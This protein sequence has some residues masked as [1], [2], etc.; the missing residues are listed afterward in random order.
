MPIFG[1]MPK[2]KGGDNMTKKTLSEIILDKLADGASI[3]QLKREY[4]LS[5][6]DIITAALFGVA[7]LREEYISLIAKRKKFR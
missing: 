6:E 3:S 1:D 4:G 7:E 5:K 2:P